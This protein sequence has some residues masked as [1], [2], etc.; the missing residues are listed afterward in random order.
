MFFSI[1][2]MS[3]EQYFE[4]AE[5]YTV[6]FLSI[7]SQQSETA[8]SWAEKAEL[9]EQNHEVYFFCLFCKNFDDSIQNIDLGLS[10]FRPFSRI[11][12]SLYIMFSC[13]LG[14][15]IFPINSH[16]SVGPFRIGNHFLNSQ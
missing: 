8:I 9:S 16:A 3:S 13:Q 7:V 14:L 12:S 15:L 10:G 11:F 5:L 4:V 2:V 6:T 1:T